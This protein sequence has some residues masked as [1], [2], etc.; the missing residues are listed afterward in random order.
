VTLT[1]AATTELTEALR[2]TI[3]A[4]LDGVGVLSPVLDGVKVLTPTL[5]GVAALT[6]EVDSI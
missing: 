1:P 4:I 6:V 2:H 5:D 3:E